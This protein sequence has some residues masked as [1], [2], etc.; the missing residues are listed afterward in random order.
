MLNA[1]LADF[2][3]IFERDPAARNWLEVLFCYPGLQA[4]LFHRFAHRLYILGIPFIPRLI[5]HIA[6][7]FTGIEIHPGASIGK[8]VF[9]DH[10]MGVVIGE[11]AI[12][13]DYALIYQGVTLGGTGKESGKRHPTLGENVVVGA[14]AKVL[15]NIQIGNSVRI[16]AGSVVLR[17]VPSNCTVVGIPGRIIYR[18]GVR[19]NPLEHGSLPDSEAEVIRTLVDRIESLEQQLQNLQTQVSTIPSPVPV[20]MAA[21]IDSCER[22]LLNSDST[23]RYLKSCRIR[24]KAIQEFLDGA[25]I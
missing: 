8:G 21:A 14:G 18:S 24:D 13:G 1:L 16:G 2:R 25:G 15:G 19:V 17:D 4:L 22:A 7:F 10:G 9:I 23:D 20:S 3:I 5:S 12:V 11:T 6:R